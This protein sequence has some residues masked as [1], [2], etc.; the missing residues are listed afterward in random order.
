MIGLGKRKGLW[1]VNWREHPA[2][3]IY[4]KR[5][6]KIAKKL[7]PQRNHGLEINHVIEDHPLTELQE[8]CNVYEP[9]EAYTEKWNHVEDK[10]GTFVSAN[11]IPNT[12]VRN[13]LPP[14]YIQWK[15]DYRKRFGR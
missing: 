1:Y 8:S 13:D 2:K 15:D 3:T 14:L 12:R 9:M 4:D 5:W 6:D 11:P 7:V 10:D